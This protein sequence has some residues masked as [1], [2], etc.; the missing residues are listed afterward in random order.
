MDGRAEDWVEA[1]LERAY[2]VAHQIAL[3]YYEVLEGAN[4]RAK[5]TGGTLNKTTVRV[6]RRHN[7]LYIEWV[8]IYFYR[9]SDGGL[10][11]SSKTIRKGRGT[12]E[13]ALATLLKST[14]DPEVQRAI[15]EAE[16][17]FAVLRRQARTLVETRKWLRRAEE[18]RSAIADLAARHAV[19]QEDN[20]LELED[21]G[22]G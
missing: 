18:A 9:K 5:E 8:R 3:D 10:G 14:P 7:S 4:D 13:Y 16:E 2:R 12:Q 19:D 15:G 17:Q 21:E 20:A 1:E 22:H 6:R 11:R